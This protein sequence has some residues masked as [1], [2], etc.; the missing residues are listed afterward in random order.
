MVRVYRA[1]GEL[2]RH[3]RADKIVR[4]LTILLVV[5]STASCSSEDAQNQADLTPTSAADAARGVMLPIDQQSR[6]FSDAKLTG[7]TRLLGHCVA[8]QDMATRRTAL[9]LWPDGTRLIDGAPPIVRL[10]N[11]GRVLSVGQKAVLG[12]AYVDDAEGIRRRVQD[13][14]KCLDRNPEAYVFA[15]SGVVE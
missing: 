1:S 13:L 10:P 11:G 15:A 2:V 3:D 12:G 9:I 14:D 4:L 8:V 5:V 6:R 7:Q